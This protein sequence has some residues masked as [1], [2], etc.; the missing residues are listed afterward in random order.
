MG[1]SRMTFWASSGDWALEVAALCCMWCNFEKKGESWEQQV[2]EATQTCCIPSCAYR[3]VYNCTATFSCCD[4]PVTVLEVILLCSLCPEGSLC[5]LPCWLLEW[6]FYSR[7]NLSVR[8][9]MLSSLN[10]HEE[11]SESLIPG[12]SSGLSYTLI[13]WFPCCDQLFSEA[14]QDPSRD[15]RQYFRN[16]ASRRKTGRTLWCWFETVTVDDNILDC[17]SE[18]HRGSICCLE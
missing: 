5:A 11:T 7:I 6:I 8:K 13:Q 14:P 1:N 15:S 12:I 3:K 2:V 18:E 4:L 9:R 16:T 17:G 10:T